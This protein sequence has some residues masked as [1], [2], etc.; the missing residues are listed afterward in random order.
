MIR[1]KNKKKYGQH[2]LI[3]E[4]TAFD[5]VN[6]LSDKTN[7]IEIGPGK[8]MLTKYLVN[9]NFDKFIVNEID[10]DC[11][12][13]LKETFSNN[14]VILHDDIL[15]LDFT[16]IFKSKFSIIS[17][18]PYYVSSQILFKVLENR[19]LVS[20]F[21]ILIQREVGERICSPHNKKSYGILSVLL[22]TY[23]KLSLE[24]IVDPNLFNPP[25]KVYSAVV[26]GIRNDVIDIGIDYNFYKNIVKQSFQNRRKTLKNSL[27]NLNLPLEFIENNIFSKR[28]EQLTVN[29]F[30]WLAKEIKK[31]NNEILSN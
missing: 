31:I 18:L 14:L 1:I 21:V 24:F 20:E 22:Q 7:V 13:F 26:K 6:L 2:F 27:K 8:G 17:N 10:D 3:C 23:F 30:I 5:I 28:A 15:K 19:L 9:K 4:D 11:V 29:E 12:L 25:P 16:T